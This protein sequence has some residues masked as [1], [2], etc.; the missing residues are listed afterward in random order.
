MEGGRDG[1]KLRAFST[2]IGQESTPTYCL[3]SPSP[4]SCPPA[5]EVKAAASRPFPHPSSK[6]LNGLF[7]RLFVTNFANE[8][9]F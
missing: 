5:V 4:L 8:D 2:A 7:L 3:S 6:T 9:G 1:S